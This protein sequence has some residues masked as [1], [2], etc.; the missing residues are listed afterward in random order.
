MNNLR[1]Q[2]R[3]D[4][5]AMR[6]VVGRNCLELGGVWIDE[7]FNA[8]MKSVTVKAKSDAYFRILERQ[9][10]VK[11]VFQLGNH[12]VWVTPSGTALIIDTNDGKEKLSG[13]GDRCAVCHAEVAS[14]SKVQSWPGRRNAKVPATWNLHSMRFANPHISAGRRSQVARSAYRPSRY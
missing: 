9:P 6:N 11:D 3:L 5:S 1:N 4:P 8:K 13:R 10:E 2:S 12:L 14:I 7:G